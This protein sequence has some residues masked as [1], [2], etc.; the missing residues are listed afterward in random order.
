MK[1]GVYFSEGKIIQFVKMEGMPY[2]ETLTEK[3]EIKESAIIP[4]RSVLADPDDGSVEIKNAVFI[5]NTE[6]QDMRF[7]GNFSEDGKILFQYVMAVGEKEN[8]ILLNSQDGTLNVIAQSES[9]DDITPD[10]FK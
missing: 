6:T 7:F 1:H 3:Y 10:Y 4:T 2:E 5:Y 8:S 9:R